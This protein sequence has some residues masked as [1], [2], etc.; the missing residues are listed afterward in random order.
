MMENTVNVKDKSGWVKFLEAVSKIADSA[1]LNLNSQGHAYAIVSS[2]D[3]TLILYGETDISTDRNCTL[4]VPD[5]KKLIRALDSIPSNDISLKVNSNNIE[6]SGAGIK[7]KYHLYEDGFLSRPSINID[8]IKAFKYDLSFSLKKDKFQSILK[9]S[10][11]ASETNKLYLYTENGTL[12]GEL[13]D[14]ARH[15]TDVLAMDLCEV[16]FNLSP[17]PINLDNIKLLTI[18]GDEISF[19]VNTEYG[20][21]II[22]ICSDKTKLKYIITSLTQ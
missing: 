9:G 3:N 19:G 15:N 10:T 12:K 17:L 5:L 21:V 7:F 16:D 1:I 13:T 6:Y 22:D 20:V 14:R 4:N 11:F 2:S 8:K 18:A